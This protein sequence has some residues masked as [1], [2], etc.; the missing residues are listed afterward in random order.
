METLDTLV[1]NLTAKKLTVGC[2]ALLRANPGQYAPSTAP[3]VAKD[4][5]K[6]LI[7]LEEKP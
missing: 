6:A 7:E 1:E 4:I 2:A 5:Q 3:L